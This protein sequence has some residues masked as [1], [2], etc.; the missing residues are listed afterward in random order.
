MAAVLLCGAIACNKVPDAERNFHFVPD[1]TNPTDAAP[2]V[3]GDWVID[4]IVPGGLA[5]KVFRGRD[6]EITGVNQ[7]VNVLELNLMRKDLHLKFHYGNPI[8]EPGELT[9]DQVQALTGRRELWGC[10]S[11]DGQKATDEVFAHKR[12]TE[13]AVACVNGAYEAGS[14][15]ER[16]NGR[17]HA[18]IGS[19]TI[20]SD[21]LVPQWKSE[22][23]VVSDGDQD[24]QILCP[25]YDAWDIANQRSFYSSKQTEWPNM[26]SSS[27]LLVKD[28]EKVGTTFT[29]RMDQN[30]SYHKYRTRSENPIQHQNNTHPRTVVALVEDNAEHAG[31]DKC[32]LITIDG[33]STA[34]VGMSA[35]QVTEFITYHFPGIKYALNMD[36]GGSTCMCVIDRG[37]PTTNVVNYPCD[38]LPAYDHLG[39]RSVNSHFYIT[40]DK[41]EETPEENEEE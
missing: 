39:V 27:P 15:W 16:T 6:T 5:W 22:A 37:D 14:V 34:S 18:V 12:S 38:N 32:L 11:G 21:P 8:G 20:P 23:C 31:F 1:D 36:G 35:A 26:F 2:V 17:T 28:G 4:S 9:Q 30:S 13:G 29:S 41:P 3:Y 40:W 19:S 24:V 25:G 33:R 7:L 10:E